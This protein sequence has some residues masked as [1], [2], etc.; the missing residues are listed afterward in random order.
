[1]LIVSVLLYAIYNDSEESFFLSFTD[2]LLPIT[3]DGVGEH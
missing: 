2:V 1:M 3:C